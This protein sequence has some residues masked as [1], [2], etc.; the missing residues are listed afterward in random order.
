[1]AT[2]SLGRLTVDLIAKTELLVSGM[3]KAERAVFEKSKEMEKRV[4][5]LNREFEDLSRKASAG[6]KA[7]AATAV[8]AAGAFAYMTRQGMQQVGQLA[9]F[10]DQI[11]IASEEL[12]ALRYAAQ[13]FS[14]MAEGT[15]DV[16]LRRMTRRIAEAAAGSGP[17]VNAIKSLRLEATELAR[18]TPDQQ[19]RAIA[20]AMQSIGSQG[21]RLRT[22][23]AIFDTEG[24]PLVNTLS[25]GAD[26]IR[27]MEQEAHALG[28]TINRLDAA[29]VE[30]AN[31][32][33]DRSAKTTQA[34]FQQ[35][36]V[37]AAPVIEAFVN[38]ITGASNELGG[39]AENAEWAFNTIVSAASFAANAVDGFG[40]V[41][42]TLAN[43]WIVVF[44]TALQKAT[45][46]LGFFV[47]LLDKIPG[48]DLSDQIQSIR[49][50]AFITESVVTQ[51]IDKIDTILTEPLAGEKFKEF[52]KE[53]QQAAQQAVQGMDFTPMTGFEAPDTSEKDAEKLKKLKEALSGRVDALRDT[54]M[55]EEQLL[56]A[57][58]VRDMQLLEEALEAQAIMREDY[59]L[60]SL[61]RHDK[62]VESMNALDEKRNQVMVRGMSGAFSAI[63]TLMNSE[64]RKLF[65]IG[66]MGALAQATVSMYQG[67]ME[68]WALGPI[69]GPILAPL[70]ATAGAA[71]IAAISR[72]RFG[73]GAGGAVPTQQINA[74]QT[75][76]G[77]QERQVYLH[78]I[79]PGSM[80]SGSQ[81]LD[82]LN[83]ELLN[84]GRLVG[85]R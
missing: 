15:F 44:G 2:R 84:G 65:E 72:T 5:Q 23:M 49:D 43:T 77:G 13:Q 39:M 70:V 31:A 17:A 58:Y 42:Q 55:T 46:A 41:M 71:N 19:F 64:S 26:A 36:A 4:K 25:K 48:L 9:A 85:V 76:V 38:R 63:S 14:G 59:D 81:L 80:Y 27:Q 53:A 73:G 20:D 34:F 18:M 33:L 10:S 69:L 16:S 22:T 11:G 30:A 61:E 57:Q 40:R 50:F 24:V 83:G 78:G 32:A 29:K 56:G 79:D 28:L 66:K 37:Q 1:M 7:L 45:E 82:M 52:V 21:Q 74:G 51:S 35:M 3:D 12:G 62:Y 47:N 54:L 68:A 67:V 75:G 6:L 8:A 60:L